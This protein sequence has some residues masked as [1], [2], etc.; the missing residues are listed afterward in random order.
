[1]AVLYVQCDWQEVLREDDGKAWITFK[2]RGEKGQRAFLKQMGMDEDLPCVKATS[3]EFCVGNGQKN[4]IEVNIKGS[5]LRFKVVPPQR[6]FESVHTKQI[7]GLDVSDGGLGVSTGDDGLFV[8]ETSRGLV[9]RSLDGHVGD[10]YTARLFPSGIVVLTAGAD[11]RVKIWSAEDGSC[12]VTLTGH[13][14]AI[15]HTAIVDEGK[16]IVTVSKDGTVRLW[17]CG[18]KRC[19]EPV[20]RIQE[21]INCCDILQTDDYSNILSSIDD[22][23]DEDEVGTE[24]KIVACGC[25]SG[26]V[27]LIAL[28]RREVIT[29]KK[30][31][32]AVNCVKFLG[33][34]RVV[35]GCQDGSITI[36]SL[37][38]LQVVDQIHDS[39][40][41]LLNVLQLRQGFLAGKYD[42]SCIWYGLA[43]NGSVNNNRIVL[44]GA[45]VDPINGIAT[46]GTYIF[47][48]AR[49]GAIRKYALSDMF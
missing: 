27:Y 6:V 37:T 1:M 33:D 15:T 24:D 31:N 18:K 21:C 45:D 46:D 40:S 25:E 9:R 47:T 35:A 44:T 42:G 8:W 5:P 43:D 28:R 23:M 12:P 30:L 41:S 2:K 4:M 36:L 34:G 20:V 26:N 11:M 38:E 13:T 39:D 32:S 22:S 49:D 10:V 14:A 29:S 3:D 48:G 19:I 16:N 17:S 7:N